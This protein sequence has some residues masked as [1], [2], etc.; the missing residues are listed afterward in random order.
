MTPPPQC[1]VDGCRFSGGYARDVVFAAPPAA[2][3]V[4]PMLVFA[5]DAKLGYAHLG[6]H[7]PWLTGV[8]VVE[9]LRMAWRSAKH[10]VISERGGPVIWVVDHE[11]FEATFD[12]ARL[13]LVSKA[14][15]SYKPGVR[16]CAG[17]REEAL[18]AQMTLRSVTQRSRNR[19]ADVLYTDITTMSV[20]EYLADQPEWMRGRQFPIARE[21]RL[22][23]PWRRGR[24]YAYHYQVPVL[25]EG[26]AKLTRVVATAEERALIETDEPR[27]V[28]TRD[29]MF[30]SRNP[31]GTLRAAFVSRDDA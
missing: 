28:R 27:F 15:A 5:S 24:K 2:R 7:F 31:N 19:T 12:G 26:F 22:G 13:T 9:Q 17:C 23:R 8:A 14:C 11:A 18:P 3:G 16:C 29:V 6:K 21:P 1:L 4:P 10:T 30:S 25:V 20:E